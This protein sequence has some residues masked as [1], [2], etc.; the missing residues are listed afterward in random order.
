MGI[1]SFT[2]GA[3]F[4]ITDQASGPLAT[5]G[6]AF[7]KL[8]AQATDLK[9]QFATIGENA[10]P[11]LKASID[12][13]YTEVG[14]LITQAR[15]LATAWGE[16]GAA[17]RGGAGGGGAGGGGGGRSG[18][19]AGGNPDDY[20]Y[21]NQLNEQNYDRR[22][23]GEVNRDFDAVS[24]QQRREAEY[25][26]RDFD[27]RARQAEREGPIG[28]PSRPYWGEGDE[29][30]NAWYENRDVDRASAK[31]SREQR[32][33]DREGSARDRQRAAAYGAIGGHVG[34]VFQ[35]MAPL[36]GVLA[37]FVAEKNAMKENR[38]LSQALQEMGYHI[39]DPGFAELVEGLRGKVSEG[40]LNTIYSE[41][42][43][44]DVL[45]GTA[46]QFSAVFATP[47]ERRE[48]YE[49]ILPEALKF[50]EVAEQYHRGD[51]QSSLKAAVGYAHMTQRYGADPNDPK[52]DL[53]SGLDHFMALLMATG[54]T[55]ANEQL[56]LKYSVPIGMA[57]GMSPDETS[58]LTGFFQ[59]MGFQG[60]TAGTGL[61]Q[62][63]LGLTHT[64][65]P[66]AAQLHSR[67][68]NVG[69]ELSAALHLSPEAIR[70]GGPRAR[71]EKP[72]DIAMRALGLYDEHGKVTPDIL[73]SQGNLQQKPF[74]EHIM[75]YL[76]THKPMENLE[77][78]RDAFT[79]RG[80]REA[81]TLGEKDMIPRLQAYLANQASP[82]KVDTL[83][84]ELST[85]PLQQFEQM[86]AN[87][88]NIGN[89]LATAT[90]E[91][92][93]KAFQTLN[94]GLVGI[95]TW[96]KEHQGASAVIGDTGLAFGA[97]TA[98]GVV[99]M[100][101]RGLWRGARSLSRSVLGKGAAEGG[102]DLL[103]ESLLGEGAAAG[104]MGIGLP[105]LAGGA[106]I[107]GGGAVL[108]GMNA[109]FQD[110]FGRQIGNIGW[111]G[112]PTNNPT[113]VGPAQTTVNLGGIH[114][115]GVVGD[116]MLKTIM[117]KV[118]SALRT[119]LHSLGVG[120]QAGGSIMSVYDSGA[121]G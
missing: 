118:V 71:Q 53:G 57:A 100:G 27:M 30:D 83:Q 82:P 69:R 105:L 26:N 20:R 29:Y 64:G 119:S 17:M 10:F 56:V 80:S 77:T 35:G 88:S 13:A 108:G 113:S 63:I 73:D 45:P 48:K 24:R 14:R 97:A 101:A 114:I 98:L 54:E 84:K 72:H 59:M 46:G 31:D 9:D 103:G 7:A 41:A 5:I 87:I 12:A 3:V 106:A 55:A 62:M 6:E 67:Q 95:N 28:P 68:E 66:V 19:R 42:H 76:T 49:T 33:L 36:I 81:A 121:A 79:V 47:E 60:T 93:N 52:H 50:A 96:L 78:L 94:T 43:G 40:T 16:A 111:G 99:G 4:E 44:A 85:L 58:A 25:E 92:L 109:P 37:P 8:A 107:L 1:S 74:L 34:G 65:G 75:G 116:D 89:T 11:G 15:E 112:R 70:K 39:G 110:E 18:P 90:L 117:D 2:V 102:A 104:G 120:G 23:A 38:S 22:Y 51:I 115:T 21:A 32:K 61:G 91:P 86:V